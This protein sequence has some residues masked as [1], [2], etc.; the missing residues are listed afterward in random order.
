[1]MT[2]QVECRE[3]MVTKNIFGSYIY[4]TKVVPGRKKME[5]KKEKIKQLLE[6]V[7]DYIEQA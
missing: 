5:E 4:N 1:M 3:S 2:V 6:I 7:D